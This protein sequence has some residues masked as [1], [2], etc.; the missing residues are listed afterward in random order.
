MFNF[1]ALPPLALY[2]HI[3]WCVRKCPYCDFNSHEKKTELPERAY[4]DTLLD[5][6][7]HDLPRVW[8]RGAKGAERHAMGSSRSDERAAGMSPWTLGAA[9]TAEPKGVAGAT[10]EAGQSSDVAGRIS[11]IFI[12]GGTPSL[13]SPESLDRLLSGL[14]A[15]LVFNPNIEITLEANPGASELQKFH[16]FRAAGINR[17]SIGIQSFN[18]DKLHA[19]GRIHGRREA[20]AAAEMAH[21]AGFDNFNLDLMFALPE[22]RIEQELADVNTAIALEPTHISLYQLTIEPNT[23]FH[24]H[25]PV[26]PDDD[27]AWHMQEQCQLRLA[28]HGFGQY[29]ISAYAR[30]GRQCRHNLN[31]WEFGD[32]LGIGAGA[33][34]KLTAAP[35]QHITRLW[36]LKQPRAYMEKT[37]APEGN[38]ERIASEQRSPASPYIDG[39]NRLTPDD[40]ALEFMMN[41]LR[42]SNGF[43]EQLFAQHAGLPLSHIEGPLH[44]AQERGWLVWDN[45]TIRPTATGSRLLNDLLQLFMPD[46]PSAGRKAKG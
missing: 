43:A 25:T 8:G 33:H 26:L 17:L 20:I 15:R 40:A 46:R 35:Q 39:E 23:L 42:L 41:A 31:Y 13:F 19:L 38:S 6:L 44:T 9:G 7:E 21:E 29:E 28:E 16:E 36:K 22:Q 5:D 14:R 12:G 3:P 18:D 30:A 37:A 11:S 32:Y 45:H 2:I 24:S 4:V 27:A 10:S 1:A 34:A